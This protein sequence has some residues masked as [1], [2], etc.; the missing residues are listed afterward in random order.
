MCD[1]GSTKSLNGMNKPEV[2]TVCVFWKD[3]ICPIMLS[4]EKYDTM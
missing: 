3:R 2:V 4:G 1:L